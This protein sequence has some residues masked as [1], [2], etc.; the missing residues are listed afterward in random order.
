MITIVNFL[1]ES[2]VV[3][4]PA[5]YLG[6]WCP[7]TSCPLKLTLKN[8]T[9]FTFPVQPHFGS[10]NTLLLPIP[11]ECIFLDRS[12]HQPW[13]QMSLCESRSFIDSDLNNMK[14]K[15]PITTNIETKK[16]IVNHS[17]SHICRW[18]SNNDN[19]IKLHD[20]VI[21]Y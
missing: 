1:L 3:Q 15:P 5:G 7:N 13:W 6:Y 11:R 21:I 20:Y 19:V 16:N 2:P 17:T 14:V 10:L 9:F 18:H 4:T 12:Q 8:Y